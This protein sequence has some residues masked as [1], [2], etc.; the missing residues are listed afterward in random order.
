M[1]EMK[2]KVMST[3]FFFSS[4]P[5]ELHSMTGAYGEIN[6]EEKRPVLLDKLEG[7]KITNAFNKNIFC[8]CSTSFEENKI[9]FRKV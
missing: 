5:K 9:I 1:T 6:L 4:T 7:G 8:H 3:Y 2:T